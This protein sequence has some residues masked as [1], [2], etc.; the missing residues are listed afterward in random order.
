MALRDILVKGDERLRKHCRPVT[1]FD[2]RLHMLLDDMAETMYAAPGVGLAAPQVGIIRRVAVVDVG[3]GLIEL[4]NPQIIESSGTQTGN[5]AC[6][7]VPQWEAQVTRPNAVKVRAQDRH[8]KTFE[9]SGEEFL[10]R[11]LCH[12]IDHLQGVLFLDICEKGTEEHRE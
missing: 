11:A 8:G 10:A 4:V 1:S 3:D 7:S 12:E 2:K 9:V 5:E 6:L